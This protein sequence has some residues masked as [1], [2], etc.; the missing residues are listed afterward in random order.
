M[1]EAKN[2]RQLFFDTE[3]T[4]LEKEDRILQ[5]GIVEVI[6]RK[7]TNNEYVQLINPQHTIGVG[8]IEIHGITQEK[9]ADAPVFADIIDELLRYI[10]GDELIIHNAPFDVS[11]MNHEIKL[12]NKQGAN[13]KSLEEYATIT[14]SLSMARRL[15]ASAHNSLNALCD[16]FKINR[17][18]RE[19]HD[20]LEDCRLLAKVYICMTGGQKSLFSNPSEMAESKH[21]LAQPLRD[22]S[23]L[24]LPEVAVT[25]EELATHQAFMAKNS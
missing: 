25:D 14:D 8:A 2:Y 24:K 13:Y 19:L 12:L 17:E 16:R 20:A 11:M 18:H 7:I 22:Y 1:S 15:Y 9:I 6:D 23:Q 10:D 5:I 3:T 21:S 4:G